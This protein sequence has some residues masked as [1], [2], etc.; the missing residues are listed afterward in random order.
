MSDNF[1][2]PV[3]V[4]TKIEEDTPRSQWYRACFFFNTTEQI[5]FIWE[6]KEQIFFGIRLNFSEV[7]FR[8][9]HWTA[10]LASLFD[11]YVMARVDYDTE[12]KV[13]GWTTSYYPAFFPSLR[14]VAFPETDY[15]WYQINVSGMFR[16]A[17]N[18]IVDTRRSEVEI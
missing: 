13:M 12:C 6:A 4:R 11:K 7:P 5:Y 3:Q 16:L 9:Q 18:G 8:Q 17:P 1:T 10:D 2:V 14:L 15:M